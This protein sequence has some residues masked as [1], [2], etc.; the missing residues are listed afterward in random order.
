M[1]LSVLPQRPGLHRR[2]EWEDILQKLLPIV[3]L[4]LALS[5]WALPAQAFDVTAATGARV[6]MAYAEARALLVRAGFQG[7]VDQS[8][9]TRCGAQQAVCARYPSEAGRC[10]G[11]GEAPCRFAFKSRDDKRAIVV[12]TRGVDLTVISLTGHSTE[13]TD[14]PPGYGALPLP[15]KQDIPADFSTVICPDAASAKRMLAE[16]Y[17][18]GQ[19]WFDGPTFMRGLGVTGCRQMSGPLQ[20]GK[21]FERRVLRQGEGSTYIRYEG[22]RP[23]GEIVSGIV[24]EE[25]N[26]SHPRTPFEHWMRSH[27]PD[28]TVKGGGVKKTYVCAD[29]AAAIK[30]VAAIPPARAKGVNNPQQVRA[31]DEA[32]RAS[33]CRRTQET[34]RVTAVHRSV[35]VILGY[36]A[37]ESWTALTAVDAQGRA[38]GLLHD[39]DLQ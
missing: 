36:E 20:I 28:G 21:V 34:Y 3:S 23:N 16:F 24:H 31:R 8:D 2:Q 4:A 26:N 1:S 7:S 13:W 33:G 15:A 30:V 9:R 35:F 17:V 6:G 25:G 12:D 18:P 39:A 38:I 5:G 37:S 11:T 19:S 29:A 22:R 10:S 32:I 14:G 27:A